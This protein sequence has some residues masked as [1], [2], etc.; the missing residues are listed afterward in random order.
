MCWMTL[1]SLYS[2]KTERPKI[3]GKIL[4]QHNGESIDSLSDRR[5]IEEMFG[6]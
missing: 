1:R 5:G 2:G 4:K 6:F 3:A